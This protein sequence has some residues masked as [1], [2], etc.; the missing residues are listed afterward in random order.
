[1]HSTVNGYKALVK[2]SCS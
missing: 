2:Y 1:M